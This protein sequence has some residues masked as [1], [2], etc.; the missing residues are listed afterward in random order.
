[1]TDKEAAPTI[2]R[3][4]YAATRVIQAAKHAV[5]HL[6]VIH[7]IVAGILAGGS[8][9]DLAHA[10]LTHL[11][12]ALPCD[13]ATLLVPRRDTEA[14]VLARYTDGDEQPDCA[15]PRWPALLGLCRRTAGARV[16]PKMELPRW[17]LGA[18]GRAE[19]L[20]VDEG[21]QV[22]GVLVLGL[23][24]EAAL[25]S[26]ALE[27]AGTL[28]DLL[29]LALSPCGPDG[30]ASGPLRAA[31]RTAAIG[32]ERHNALEA[33]LKEA[34]DRLHTAMVGTIRIISSTV[35]TWDP[36]TAG[37][38]RH[39]AE[40]AVA[41]AREL[42]WE[43]EQIEGLRM[44]GLVHDLGKIALPPEMLSRPSHLSKAEY[45]IVKA[46]ADVG[47]N[48]LKDID[49]P[50]PLAQVV[51]QHH[52]RL[53]GSGYPKGLIESEILPEAKVLAVCDTVES[54]VSPRTYRPA[55]GVDAA[56]A[57]ITRHRGDRFDPAVVDACVRLF[58]EQR[59][60][61]S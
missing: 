48:L 24:P 22:L 45:E 11:V 59:F 49:F 1:M 28:A 42:G 35:E 51:R 12:G 44:A 15:L 30:A 29:G 33:S 8:A 53:D 50:W 17:L 60:A 55:L 10:A 61:F 26:E 2:W 21:G 31:L 27:L 40:L 20:A 4:P 18:G 58:R 16:E 41:I 19:C 23:E 6:A 37:H 32:L 13:R 47:Y 5:S 43:P 54:M 14:V 3:R 38:Q 52:E 25:S 7:E 57:D 39:V 56:L 34:V 9:A 36:F 46:H